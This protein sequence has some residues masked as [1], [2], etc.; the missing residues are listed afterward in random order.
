MISTQLTKDH[1]KRRKKTKKRKKKSLL[2]NET[3]TWER[4]SQV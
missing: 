4:L 2:K 1:Q 3:K